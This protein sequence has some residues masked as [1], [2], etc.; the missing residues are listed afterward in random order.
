MY[1]KFFGI[2]DE[3]FSIAPNPHYLYMSRQ[4]HEALAHLVYGI[5]K[6]GFITLTGEVGTGKTTVCRCFLEQV[7][8]DTNV[9]FILNP[10]LSVIELLAAI[11][12]ELQVKHTKGGILGLSKDGVKEYVDAINE[13][14]LLA[15]AEGRK[16]LLIIDEAQNLSIDVLEQIRLLTNLETNKRKLLQ[17]VL[18]G[19]PELRDLFAKPELRQLAQRITARFHLE[20]LSLEETKAY[21]TH[22]LAIAGTQREIF[23]VP[24]IKC[25]HKISGGIPR[26][27]NVVC[28]RALLG[29]YV[30]NKGEVDK[31]T[32]RRAAKEVLG[33]TS[34]TSLGRGSLKRKEA[35]LMPVR[36]GPGFSFQRVAGMLFLALMVPGLM[37]LGA[38]LGLEPVTQLAKMQLDKKPSLVSKIKE[39]KPTSI[40]APLEFEGQS[41]DDTYAAM[42]SELQKELTF[43]DEQLEKQFEEPAMV[44]HV[45]AGVMPSPLPELEISS[46]SQPIWIQQLWPNNFELAFDMYDAYDVIFDRWELNY[47]VNKNGG[48]PCQFANRKGM[49]CLQKTGQLGDLSLLDRPA[50]LKFY[51]DSG[52]HFYLP[53]VSLEGDQATLSI[54]GVTRTIDAETLLQ[55]WRGEYTVVWRLPPKYHGA[56]VLGTIGPEVKWLSKKLALVQENKTLNIGISYYDDILEEKIKLFQKM[57]GITPDGVVGPQTFIRLNSAS[58]ENSPQLAQWKIDDIGEQQ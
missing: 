52:Q 43:L 47:N 6:D 13:Y 55:H 49:G 53:L 44:A 2:N 36:T 11:C 20:Q 37:L 57:E 42:D 7:P 48:D 40:M 26:I 38:W 22:R 5:K 45:N 54:A 32:L 12:D 15:H 30:Q 27:I 31:K 25:L 23:S 18:I 50:V 14:L 35:R 28:D 51:I 56:I 39:I 21:V 8:E 46:S 24:V 33:D 4:H 58:G 41:M 1:K 19:Q 17:I 16:T 10:K 3:P 9:A 29:A 34:D